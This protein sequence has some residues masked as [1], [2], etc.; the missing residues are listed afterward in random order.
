MERWGEWGCMESGGK[1][2]EVVDI[3]GEVWNFNKKEQMGEGEEKVG[4]GER[5]W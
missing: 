2:V 3:G 4:G 1:V 5:W